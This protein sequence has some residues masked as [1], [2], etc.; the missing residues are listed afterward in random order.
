MMRKTSGL[1]AALFA[2][3]VSVVQAADPVGTWRVPSGDAIVRIADC[4]GLTATPGQ[5][6]SPSGL[7]CGTVVWL[8]EPIDPATGQPRI[9]GLNTDPAKKDQPIMGMQGI[10]DMR[11]SKEPMQWEG[12]VYNIDDGKI[13]DGSIIMKSDSE[14]Y[15]QGCV[16]LICRGEEWVRQDLPDPPKLDPPKP[17]PSKSSK[18]AQAPQPARAR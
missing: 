4:A 6:V 16:M 14:I 9:D 18:P 7:L 3:S 2:L 15:V 12:R 13:Y 10:F 8:K 17:D 1:A 11:P 5:A